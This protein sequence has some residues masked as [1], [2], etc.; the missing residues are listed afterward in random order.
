MTHFGLPRVNPSRV[1]VMQVISSDE[2][3]LL[4]MI[5]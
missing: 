3:G 2:V 4:D 5:Y 1:P